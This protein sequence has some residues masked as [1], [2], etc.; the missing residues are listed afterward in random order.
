LLRNERAVF[1]GT[2][3]EERPAGHYYFRVDERFKDA[4]EGYFEIDGL[5]FPTFVG[6]FQ[7]GKQYLVFAMEWP[8][9]KK[10]ERVVVARWPTRELEYAQ[11]LLDQLRAEKNGKRN[12]SLYGTLLQRLGTHGS[13]AEVRPV[14]GAVVRVQSKGKSFETRTDE[15]GV[16]ALE[17]LPVGTYKLSTDL[18]RAVQVDPFERI[19]TFELP[20]RSCYERAISI[21]SAADIVPTAESEFAAGI[22]EREK[23]KYP[24]A[25][26]HL[27]RAVAL[28]QHMV[29]AHFVLATTAD[30]MC[31]PNAQPCPDM[32]KCGLAIQEYNRV[33]ELD[34]SNADASKNLAYL[35]YQFNRL[36][37]SESLYRRALALH[38]DDPE[39]L[40][41]VAAT[42]IHRVW[43][44]LAAAR[45][46][47]NLPAERPLIDSPLCKELR[48]RN[49]ARIEEGLTLLMRALPI[50][51][52]NLDVMAYLSAIHMERAEI[53]CGNRQAYEAE[54]NAAIE[55]DRMG[56]KAFRKKGWHDTFQKCPPPFPPM[57]GH[58]KPFRTAARAT[59]RGTDP[60]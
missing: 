55:W 31:L 17:R 20:H 53:Q 45:A 13:D 18:P 9:G 39:L 34:A 28:D 25:L 8:Y 6:R 7:I 4:K 30:E 15:H 24:A 60:R 21:V 48:N 14:A 16:Y 41:A 27:Q 47:M 54:M 40:C 29:K 12:A 36:D 23:G 42:T 22:S 37:E 11:A 51:K 46:G 50:R 58:P 10:D 49:E 38:A 32:H 3:T 2:V 43:P 26:E 52:N 33:I 19:E 1:I 44:D 5:P 57:P 35:I 59:N 56:K